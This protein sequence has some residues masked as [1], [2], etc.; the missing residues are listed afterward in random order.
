VARL[1]ADLARA[2]PAA[3][4]AGVLPGYFW[5]SFVRRTDGLAERLA[6]STA[7]SLATVPTISIAIARILGTGITLGVAITSVAIVLAS[8][9]LACRI[10]GTARSRGA[11]AQAGAGRRGGSESPALPRPR[12]ITDGK[13]LALVIVAIV[14]ALTSAIGVRTPSWLPLIILAAVAAAGLLTHGSAAPAESQRAVSDK[15]AGPGNSGEPGSPAGPGGE[16]SGPGDAPA[17][18]LV[19]A[20]GADGAVTATAAPAAA[21]AAPL[22]TAALAAPAASAAPAP[23]ASTAPTGSTAAEA[24][25]TAPPALTAST[26]QPASA[27][28]AAMAV[29]APSDPG[30]A[31]PLLNRALRAPALLVVLA[32][33][34]VRAYS[35]VI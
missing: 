23:A 4:A 30:A 29:A 14:L 12:A 6:Y 8:G 17:P 25:S 13:A 24:A 1:I 11:H 33:T 35:G 9:A 15:Q 22:A 5:A 26:A 34:A 20:Q 18:A 28:P 7:V 31:R 32:L 27:A 21:S 2:L 19:A 10:W 3:L 16:S